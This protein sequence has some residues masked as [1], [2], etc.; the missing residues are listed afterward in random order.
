MHSNLF[1]YDQCVEA[2]QYSEVYWETMCV[3]CS[4]HYIMMLNWVFS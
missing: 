3:C 1:I 2:S 4:D